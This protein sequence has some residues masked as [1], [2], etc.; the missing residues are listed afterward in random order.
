VE[1]KEGG[2]TEGRKLQPINDNR[3]DI[4]NDYVCER[5]TVGGGMDEWMV[6]T[7]S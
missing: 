2:P 6:G 7:S 3:A 4:M 1:R 5:G